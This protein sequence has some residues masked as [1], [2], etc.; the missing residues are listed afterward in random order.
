M[1]SLY[2]GT[3][4]SGKS[5]SVAKQIVESIESGRNV[6]GN[7]IVDLSSIYEVNNKRRK[8]KKYGEYVFFNNHELTPEFLMSYAI[9]N[10]KKGKEGQTVVIWDEVQMAFSPSVVKSKCQENKNYRIQWLDFFTQHRHLGYDVIFVTPF[11]KLI[12][13]Q[14][15]DLIEYNYIHRKINNFGNAFSLFLDCFGVKL[16]AQIKYWY[17]MK[18]R[19]EGGFFFYNKKYARIYDSYARFEQMVKDASADSAQE[20]RVE[21]LRAST[22]HESPRVNVA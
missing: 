5:L 16:F 4:G 21:D 6:I 7:M 15:R 17:G 14:L 2:S 1:I 9:K 18:M 20:S 19:I 13:N 8:P 12:D 22:V 3:P 11:D 10:H